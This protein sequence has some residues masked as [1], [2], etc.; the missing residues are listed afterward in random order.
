MSEHQ[1]PLEPLFGKLL[2]PFERFL[3]QTTSGGIVLIGKTLLTLILASSPWGEAYRHMWETALHI[4]VGFYTIKMPV[5]AW[6]NEGLMTLFFLLV[7][8]ELK[9]AILFGDWL[10]FGMPLYP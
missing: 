2:S 1:Y 7:G 4:G 9:R 5:H 10:R 6:V 3:K 8:L